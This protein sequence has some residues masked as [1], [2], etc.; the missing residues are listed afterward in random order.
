MSFGLLAVVA[1]RGF[2]DREASW[3]LLT[4]VIVSGL[5]GAAV[6][7]PRHV[8]TRHWLVVLVATVAV[9]TLVAAITLLATRA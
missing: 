8:V 1:V 7:A 5:V 6:R 9:A 4:L 3:D 2:V